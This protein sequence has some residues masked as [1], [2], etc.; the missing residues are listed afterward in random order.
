MNEG[1]ESEEEVTSEENDSKHSDDPSENEAIDA[2]FGGNKHNLNDYEETDEEYDNIVLFKKSRGLEYLD[3][4]KDRYR[5][6]DLICS[7]QFSEIR[8]CIHK[9][10]NVE[11]SI[12]VIS[13]VKLSH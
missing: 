6:G 11:A 4:V 2:M 3:Y 5:L 13:K 7:N 8:K 10:A 9:L 1:S 12:K